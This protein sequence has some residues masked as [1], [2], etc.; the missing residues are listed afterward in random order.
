M[1]KGVNKSRSFI[2]NYP[3]FLPFMRVWPFRS[4]SVSET[5]SIRNRRDQYMGYLYQLL[6]NNLRR[7]TSP[8]CIAG[9]I[10]QTGAHGLTEANLRSICL[11]MVSAGLDTIPV[12]IVACIGHL[13]NSDY[14]L[15]LQHAAYTSILEVYGTRSAALEGCARDEQYVPYVLALI[16][17]TLRYTTSQPISLPRQTVGADIMYAPGVCIPAGTILLL[18]TVAGNFDEQRFSNPTMFDPRRYLLFPKDN[19]G[20]TKAKLTH[21]EHLGFGAG[22][23]M[24]LGYKLAEREMYVMLVHLILNFVV[25][26]AKSPELAEGMK[27][28]DGDLEKRFGNV[29]SMVLETEP[30]SVR[31]VPRM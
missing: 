5:E 27:T 3:D 24:C 15:E 6:L 16:K 13:A 8:P 7:G 17:E 25:L 10:L 22:S 9:E 30:F 23:R 28:Y 31:F 11:T 20:T 18:N 2:H 4:K 19:S 26:P 1:E 14:G 12:N 29:A 21:Q